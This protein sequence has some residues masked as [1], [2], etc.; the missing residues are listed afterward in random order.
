MC[1][2]FCLSFFGCCLSDLLNLFLCVCAMIWC[3]YLLSFIVHLPFP[4]WVHPA[5]FWILFLKPTLNTPK[6]KKKKKREKCQ[7]LC[8]GEWV[9]ALSLLCWAAGVSSSHHGFQA[10]RRL[11]VIMLSSMCVWLFW[12]SIPLMLFILYS[13]PLPGLPLNNHDFLFSHPKREE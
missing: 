5:E 11:S 6:Q 1:F 9:G 13:W 3:V 4:F 8:Y 10:T 12:Y 2:I 7:A